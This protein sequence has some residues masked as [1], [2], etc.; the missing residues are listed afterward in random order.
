MRTM[1]PL[2]LLLACGSP[3]DTGTAPLHATDQVWG[4]I[5]D[6]RLSTVPFLPDQNARY[7]RYAF[8]RPA[9]DHVLRVSGTLAEARYQALDIYDDVA[10]T[11]I[12]AQNDAALGDPYELLITERTDLEG[13][14]IAP[15]AGTPLVS[16]FL[17]LYVPE[18]PEVAGPLPLVD[19]FDPDTGSSAPP[20]PAIPPA[21]VPQALVDLFLSQM[22]VP[23]RADR[24]DFY[25][26]SADGLYAAA[27]NQYLTSYITRTPGEVALVRFLPPTWGS[28][29]EVRYWSLSQG[30]R[31]SF[32]HHTIAD[33]Q[34]TLADDQWLELVIGDDTPEL[35]EAAAGRTFVPWATPD[36]EMVL[37]YRNLIAEAGFG[38]NQARV[39]LFD[40]EAPA[41]GQEAP[42]FI[43][44]YAPSGLR[45]SQVDF[46]ATGCSAWLDGR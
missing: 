26:L 46:L 21:E 36:D 17:R 24:V 25:N 14:V 34:V 38:G 12:G 7:W 41:E 20:P 31:H 9:P 45:C 4:D 35:R 40:F 8:E 11:S 16:V 37:I 33:H 39:P 2:G 43:G 13:T 18:Q 30:D 5:F 10:R 19:L 42:D 15:P 3:T 29:G 22:E 28:G 1:L 6:G 27:D 23:Q 32:T 44:D